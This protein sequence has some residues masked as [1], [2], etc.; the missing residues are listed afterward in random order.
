[1]LSRAP[2]DNVL[3]YGAS[4][5]TGG[6]IAERAVAEGGRPVLGGRA[7]QKIRPLAERLSCPHR[8]FGLDDRGRL[9]A[10]LDGVDVVLHCAGPFS[11]TA[12]QMVEACLRTK[13]HYLDITG[14]IDVFEALAASDERAKKVGIML[15]PG[16]GFDVVPTDCLAVYLAQQLEDATHLTLAFKSSSPQLSHGT[17]LV[18]IE[19]IG[20]GAV[21]QDGKIVQVPPAWRTMDINFDGQLE[22]CVTIPWGD[23]STAFYST[24]IP[25]IEVYLAAPPQ[26]YR[27]FKAS[28]YLG[29]LL[30]TRPLQRFLKSRVPPGGPDE[31]TR[32]N[33][34]V[35]LWGKVTNA[36][37]RSVQAQLRTPEGYQ[38]TM[39]TALISARR[40]AGG[41]APVGF[42][43]PAKAYGPGL[44]L[45]VAGTSRSQ[46]E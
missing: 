46:L 11:Q 12:S 29:G 13:T 42:Q 21:R 33:A 39:L 45:E 31:A 5:Y 15:M 20:S 27:A 6:L 14:E 4:G 8:V 43:T 23:V 16:V 44:I 3:I 2:M 10:A 26:M 41:D 7:E 36:G 17:T 35:R 18:S 25:N 32:K 19:S 37:G 9:D 30:R 22:T 34:H 40:A 38:L 24:G 28:R 1:M